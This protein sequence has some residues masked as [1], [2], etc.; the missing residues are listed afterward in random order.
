MMIRDHT[1]AAT[2]PA[3]I[4]LLPNH[5]H[6]RRLYRTHFQALIQLQTLTAFSQAFSDLLPLG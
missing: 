1:F 4:D 3:R 5:S 2:P 6:L